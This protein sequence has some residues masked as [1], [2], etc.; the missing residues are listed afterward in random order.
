VP[1]SSIVGFDAIA[2]RA[3]A[4]VAA[5]RSHLPGTSI[6][7]FF[8]SVLAFWADAARA[9]GF[10]LG[11]LVV[12]VVIGYLLYR[13]IR[14]LRAISGVDR[15]PLP[16]PAALLPPE[17]IEARI[18]TPSGE[19]TVTIPVERHLPSTAPPRSIRFPL[20]LLFV[21]VAIAAVELLFYPFLFRPYDR[22]VGAVGG[23]LYW[24]QAWPGVYG[25]MNQIPLV[26]DFIFPMYL[27]LILAWPIATGLVPARAR[28]SSSR[29][30][31][32]AAIL[33]LYLATELVVDAVFF[34][35]PGVSVRNLSLIVRATV[36]GV[37]LTMTMYCTFTFPPP[38]PK[39]TA[40][41]PRDR[42]A[43]WT[44]FGMGVLAI[45]SAG[46]FLYFFSLYLELHGYFPVFT[47]LLL[48]PAASVPLW[49]LL[50]RPLYFRYHRDHPRPTLA[51]Y[52]PPVSI[53]IPAFNE[54]ADIGEAIRSADRASASYPGS[55]EIVVGNDGSTDRTSE[56]ARRAIGE[57]RH[58]RGTLVDLPHGG[59]SSALNAALHIAEGEVV[60]RLD[61][62]SRISESTGFGPAVL[63]L[64]NPEVGGVQGCLHPRQRT[65]WPRKLRAMEIA[66][67]HLFLRPGAMAARASEVI[68]GAFSVF[69]RR[70]LLELGGWLPWNGEDT[71][72]SIR[73]QRMGYR[74]CIAFDAQG[75]EDVPSN[76]RA[77]RKQRIRWTRGGVF[78]N[79]RNYPALF[80]GTLEFGGLAILFYYL[81][82]LRAGARSLVFVYLGMLTLFLGLP[83]ILH[84][85]Y[86]L[87][88]LLA[89]RTIPLGFFLVRMRRYDVLPWIATWPIFGVVKSVFRFE[90]FG[91]ILRGAAA[92]FY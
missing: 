65:G 57:L 62:D 9:A 29:R 17:A 35:V 33:L 21:F 92:E 49:A 42:R 19:R 88:A 48:L 22:L 37:F 69:R 87:L 53:L 8:S 67:Q 18:R 30:G 32:L 46:A 72:I 50:C 76:Y 66:W 23:F 54:E 36:G 73:L 7:S 58:A 83:G 60:V 11:A 89:L 41:F 28:L 3:G 68:D 84:A 78:A 6:E 90:A 56:V 34:T 61:A 5:S 20:T 10:P 86:L 74:T 75:Y 91:T 55:V 59:K 64:A 71:E 26:Y 27:A 81:L 16:E 2:Q 51:E 4:W 14:F 82:V 52:H 77:L 40:R 44:F 39:L 13:S 80:S 79:S 47:V 38:L 15:A 70:D 25:D 24:P 31:L 12:G 43:I 45:A 1:A 85:A 63:Y